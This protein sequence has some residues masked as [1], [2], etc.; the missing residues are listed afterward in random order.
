MVIKELILK[1]DKIEI[2]LKIRKYLIVLRENCQ[3]LEDINQVG[4]SLVQCYWRL[5]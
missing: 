1:S 5:N 4:F 2:R 3:S